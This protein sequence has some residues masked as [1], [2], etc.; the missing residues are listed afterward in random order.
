MFEL[1]VISG[2]QHQ[3]QQFLFCTNINCFSVLSLTCWL[4]TPQ[5][6]VCIF[7]LDFLTAKLLSEKQQ[8][9]SAK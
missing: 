9:W 6:Q 5:T 3:K 8:N 1:T 4:I 7:M 2:Y